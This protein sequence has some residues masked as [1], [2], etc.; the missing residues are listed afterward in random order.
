MAKYV[1][2]IRWKKLSDGSE[3]YSWQFD[4]G[5]ILKA[6]RSDV[7]IPGLMEPESAFVAALASCHMLSFMAVAAKQG[8][9][10]LRYN[11]TAT[12]ALEKNRNGKIA[13]T[14]ILL[15][16][17]VE[18]EGVSPDLAQLNELHEQAHAKCF[19]ANSVTSQVL[20]EPAFIT[21]TAD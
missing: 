15:Q 18:L 7:M 19:I 12:G 3:S 9:Q 11:D 4:N 1:F 10:V 17:E 13:I 8:I 14:R 6:D 16:P 21:A 2:K 20:I 5:V